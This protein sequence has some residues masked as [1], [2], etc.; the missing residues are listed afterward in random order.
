MPQISDPDYSRPF[1]VHRWSDHPE[2]K[3]VVDTL[4][5]EWLPGTEL[6]KGDG[7]RRKT[8]PK[9]KA[10]DKTH[11]KVLVLDLYVAWNEDPELS[12][13]VHMSPNEYKVGSRY[14]A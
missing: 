10:T 12:V 14:N 5:D 1:D 9:P 6:R 4:W 7:K 8:G 2:V 3:G 13:G 11:L